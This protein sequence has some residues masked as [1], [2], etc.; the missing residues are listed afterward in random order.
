MV[1]INPRSIND[2]R[3]LIEN[4]V[5]VTLTSHPGN[6]SLYKLSLWACGIPEHLWDVTCCKADANNWPMHRLYGG[7][8]EL[9][10]DESFFE[11]V[12]RETNPKHRFVTAYQYTK[13]GERLGRFHTRPMQVLFP[14]VISTC[15]HL[16][17]SEKERVEEMCTL[18]AETRDDV[19]TCFISPE[20]VMK[21]IGQSG[22]TR[23][24][25]AQSFMRVLHELDH[26][27]LKDE[28]IETYGGACYD[29]AMVPL[30]GMLVHYW[31]TGDILRSDI[32]GPD[33]IHYALQKKHQ[34]K[35][36]EMLNH[37]RS[38]KPELIPKRFISHMFPGTYARIGHIKDH[39]S[40][41]VLMRKLHILQS[42][43]KLSKE[44]KRLLWDD[45]KQDNM[46]WPISI[47]PGKTAYF[48][49]HDLLHHGGKLV[50]DEFWKDVPIAEMRDVLQKANALLRIH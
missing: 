44:E 27:L 28:H 7:T 1:L 19:F 9:I 37:L 6:A 48:S 41:A 15:S 25:Y 47:E 4:G 40:E 20:G 42:E 30:A 32:S 8:T 16:L 10:V 11:K 3:T 2:L 36:S 14:D 5:P 24:E 18:L 33:M 13:H 31:Q 46:H 43:N 50:V 17:L 29:G 39:H 49:Q 22:L 26:L 12:Q 34:A 45:A 35:L 38:W 23:N 21:P